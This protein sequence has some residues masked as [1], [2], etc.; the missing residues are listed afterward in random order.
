[1]G[2]GAE[3]DADGGGSADPLRTAI[4]GLPGL[5]DRAHTYLCDRWL[6]Q[7]EWFERKSAANQKQ[8]KRFRSV[9]IAGGVLLP[10]LVNLAAT[11]SDDVYEITAIVISVIVGLATA[12]EAF[13]RPGERWLQ[14]RQTAE[15]MRGEWWLFVSLAGPVY[16]KYSSVAAAFTNFVERT[17]TIIGEDV[18]GFVAIVQQGSKPDDDNQGDADPPVPA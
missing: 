5:S 1:M 12:L 15:R 17:E 14:Y 4:D 2:A 18:A 16:G 3:D 13:L 8:H 7:L 9:A 6:D 11:R 10:V